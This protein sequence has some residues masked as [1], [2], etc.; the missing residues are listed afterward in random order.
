MVTGFINARFLLVIGNFTMGVILGSINATLWAVFIAVYFS[1]YL[2]KL[3]T[4]ILIF[5]L[6]CLIARITYTVENA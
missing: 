2:F 5:T 4:F 1:M 6:I 3:E